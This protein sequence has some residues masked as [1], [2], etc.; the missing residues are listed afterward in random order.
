MS[1]QFEDNLDDNTMVVTVL[2]EKRQKV[3]EPRIK[4]K[5]PDIEKAVRENYTPPDTHMLGDCK[6]RMR[7]VDNNYENTR[8]GSWEFILIPNASPKKKAAKK[9][10]PKKTRK[11]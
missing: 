4:V 6:D 5:W 11:K 9:T 7:V 1:I 3:N 10:T 2:L 8:M